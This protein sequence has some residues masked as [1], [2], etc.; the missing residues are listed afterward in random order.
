VVK[1]GIGQVKGEQILPVDPGPDG[2][3]GLAVAQPLAELQ[4]RDQRQAPGRVCGLAALGIEISKASVV[5][6]G[7][8]P[9]A[10]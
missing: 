8:E 3:S 2:L 6:H 4:E 1:A 10:Q 9:V 7:A 5:E